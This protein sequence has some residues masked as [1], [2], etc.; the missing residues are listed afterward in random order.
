MDTLASALCHFKLAIVREK[1]EP[2]K[3]KKE[4]KKVPRVQFQRQCI[5]KSDR[6]QRN[7]SASP[8]GGRGEGV[9]SWARTEGAKGE[10]KAS[11]GPPVKTRPQL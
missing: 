6:W 4:K 1:K 9:W 11:D 10:G 8:S 3:K 7:D 5:S 2:E